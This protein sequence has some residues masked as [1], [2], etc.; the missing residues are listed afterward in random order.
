[1]TLLLIAA[2]I[3]SAAWSNVLQ[4]Q[5]LSD[6]RAS[7]A[8]LLVQSWA[9]MM[10]MTIPL[11]I[12]A[13]SAGGFFWI[14]MLLACALEVP[15]NW[16]LLRSLQHTDLS[17]YGPLNSIKPAISLV[18][19]LFLFGQ[20][21]SWTGLVGTLI[22]LTGSILLT[23]EPIHGASP[24][25]IWRKRGVRDRLA[26]VVLTAA[27]SVVLKQAFEF[28]SSWQVLGTWSLLGFAMPWMISLP[29]A[30]LAARSRARSNPVVRQQNESSISNDGGSTEPRAG[31]EKM[32]SSRNL[33]PPSPT[34]SLQERKNNS[35]SGRSSHGQVEVV[36]A[37]VLTLVMQGA[38]IL[39]FQ[40]MPVAYALAVFQIGSLLSVLLGYQYFGE[41]RI[42]L[43]TIAAAIMFVGAVIILAGR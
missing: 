21:P 41:G 1:M 11:W 37:A 29:C 15:G 39:T 43:R 26:A 16:L 13:L 36:K 12:S 34:A 9:W 6:S 38:T 5:L 4:K 19:A 33:P 40:R 10:L 30:V 2:R 3:G 32:L 18:L 17:V 20:A 42:V 14:W 8:R 23:Y 27:A 28:G 24:W 7:P 35:N 25:K 22:V 31:E